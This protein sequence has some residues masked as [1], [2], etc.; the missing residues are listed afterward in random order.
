[1]E[2]ARRWRRPAHEQ[3]PELDVQRDDVRPPIAWKA[4]ASRIGSRGGYVAFGV[5]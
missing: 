3:E 1:M 5:S 4:A 2:A